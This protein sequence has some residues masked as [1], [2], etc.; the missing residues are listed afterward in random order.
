MNDLL[1]RFTAAKRKLFEKAYDTLNPEQ[2]EAVFSTDAPLL[3]L[4]GAGSGKTTVLVKRIAFIIKYGNAY[5]NDDIPAGMELT[6]ENVSCLEYCASVDGRPDAQ[7]LSEFSNDSCPPW[8]VLAITFTNK[9]ADEI[10]KRLVTE[11]GDEITAKDV[12]A[13]TFHK[14]CM[15]ILRT[16]AE[17]IGYL[18]GFTVY[19]TEDSKKAITSAIKECNIDPRTLP[20]KTVMNAISRAKDQLIT[21]D[22]FLIGTSA[23]DHKA[24]LVEKVYKVYQDRLKASNAMDFDDIIMQTVF[25]LRDFE[26]VRTYYQ[27]KFR[28]VS[29]DEF[30][31]TNKAQLVLT[32]LLAGYYRNLMVV[33]DDDQS[34]YRFRGATIENILNFD[35]QFPDAKVIRLERNYRSTDVIL[36]AAN[37]VIK[38]NVG[39]HDKTLWTEMKGGEKITVRKLSDQNDEARYILDIIRR[40]VQ[41]GRHTFKDYAIL[42]RTNAQSNAIE[43][44]FAKS[45]I[46]YRMLG[47]TRFTDREEIR[48]IT[49]YL[50]LINNRNDR[51]RLLRIINK[52]RRKIG[53]VTIDA[54]LEIADYEGISPFSVIEGCE[55]YVSLA[56][57]A[58]ILLEFARTINELAELSHEVPLDV[59]VKETMERTGYRQSIVERGEEEK[60][61]LDNLD[62]FVS[63]VIDYMH[64]TDNPTL[65]GFLEENALVS[66]VDKYD[67]TADAVVMMTV[68]SSKGLEFPVVIIPGMEDGIFPGM[69]T[70]MEGPSALEEERRLAYVAI[71]RAKKELYILT[72]ES[73]LLYGRTSYNPPSRFLK[74]IP[75]KYLDM[76]KPDNGAMSKSYNL[77]TGGKTTSYGTGYT[78]PSRDAL[79]P[80]SYGNQYS[81]YGNYAGKKSAGGTQSAFGTASKAPAKPSGTGETFK[82]NDRVKHLKFG[83]GSILSV[84][85]V[86]ADTIYEIMFDDAGIKKLMAT[87][88]KLKK[89]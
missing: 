46:P 17:K 2:R 12:W 64:G 33:G 6:E 38:N 43:R 13:G 83:E 29:V 30:Q 42:Y 87:Y 22:N 36:N 28:Y 62:E 80:E 9:A 72:A 41:S 24:Q 25:L 60:D 84:T 44:A 1:K 32:E 54:I 34:I 18:P 68:H 82:V 40:N 27:K 89:I 53:N 73:R 7:M 51:E 58:K 8:Q 31:D 75:E 85:P 74:E 45:G 78:K 55:K 65:T 48:D 59:L 20:E 35:K 71:T 69:Q 37:A 67:E 52:P 3:I 86:G 76:P 66:D 15:R 88:A 56:K 70:I 4:A 14:I 47:G 5:F 63:G 81:G 21:P 26:D 11:L 19:D 39:R 50:Q 77:G 23:A 10:K 79:S 57:S 16:H 61:R 49:A